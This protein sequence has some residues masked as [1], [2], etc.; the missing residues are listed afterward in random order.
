[1]WGDLKHFE[2]HREREVMEAAKKHRYQETNTEE[3]YFP[4]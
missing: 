2:M 3:V 1:M 4:V